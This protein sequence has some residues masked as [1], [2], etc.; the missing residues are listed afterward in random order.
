MNRSGVLALDAGR[1]WHCKKP[2]DVEAM[3]SAAQYLIGHHDFSTF[4]DSECQAQSPMKTLDRAEVVASGSYEG[5]GREIVFATEARSFLHHMVRNMVGSLVM[6]GEGKWSVADFRAAF[7]ARDRRRGGVTA[8]PDGLY[9]VR[10][11]Y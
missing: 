1:A 11:D 8:P 10:V 5:Q 9:L 3:N 7:E 4:R 6:V 2:L